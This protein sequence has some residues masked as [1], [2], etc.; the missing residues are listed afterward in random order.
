MSFRYKF[1]VVDI[2]WHEV[3][4]DQRER[5]SDA[6]HILRLILPDSVFHFQ[7]VITEVDHTLHKLQTNSVFKLICNTFT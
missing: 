6:F 1:C 7:D 4:T 2:T 3:L 5:E